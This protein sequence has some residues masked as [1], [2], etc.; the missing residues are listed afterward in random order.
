M[1][2]LIP[3]IFSLAILGIFLIGCESISDPKPVS[4]ALFSTDEI[5]G[6]GTLSGGIT[7]EMCKVDPGWEALGFRNLG[8]CVRYVETGKDS[9]PGVTDIDGNVYQT[10][11]IGNQVWMAENLRTTRYSDGTPVPTDLINA[12]WGNTT[13]GAYAINP[14]SLIEG[15]KFR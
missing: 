4:D 11:T 1:K 3:L 14:H 9:R 7:K 13:N 8:Q 6:V 5:S 2:Q 15:F 12:D 10:V